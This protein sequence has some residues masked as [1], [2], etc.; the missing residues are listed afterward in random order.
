MCNIAEEEHKIIISTNSVSK[1][2][3]NRIANSEINT[4]QQESLPEF[5]QKSKAKQSKSSRIAV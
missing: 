2:K 5:E 1:S 3:Q 4:S